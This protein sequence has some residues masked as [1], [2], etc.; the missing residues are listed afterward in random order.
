MSNEQYV[1]ET[2]R[3]LSPLPPELREFVACHAAEHGSGYDEILQ[4]MQELTNKMLD[5]LHAYS[6]RIG[7]GACA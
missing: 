6:V 4:I 2:N 5:P 1:I 7:Q 3:I